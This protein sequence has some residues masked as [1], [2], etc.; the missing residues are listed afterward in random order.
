MTNKSKGTVDDTGFL[1]QLCYTMNDKARIGLPAAKRYPVLL[2][3]GWLYVGGRHLL[4]MMAGR[5]PKIHI[6]K[7]VR[8][9][10]ERKQVYKSF[11]L[12]EAE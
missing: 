4:R 10:A 6:N 3:V 11:H 5:R 12:F 7:M 2:P 8:G 1:R 9:A